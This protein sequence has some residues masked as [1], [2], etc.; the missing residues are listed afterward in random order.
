MS[1]ASVERR[2]ARGLYMCRG[3]RDRL[4]CILNVSISEFPLPPSPPSPCL[5]R[6][7]VCRR[8]LLKEVRASVPSLAFGERGGRRSFIFQK[9]SRRNR[10]SA[11]RECFGGRGG[12][13][14]MS[15]SMNPFAFAREKRNHTST[16][17]TA[18]SFRRARRLTASNFFRKGRRL[19]L[20]EKTLSAGN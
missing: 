10:G 9:I 3:E 8:G 19:E 4:G 18:Q 7:C 17:R 15:Q 13:W 20:T 11:L 16:R 5:P 12:A 1:S 6:R 14:A 2:T